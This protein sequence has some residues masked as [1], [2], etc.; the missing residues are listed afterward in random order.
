V[1]AEFDVHDP[2][3]GAP[4]NGYPNF[5]YST[6][7]E[8]RAQAVGGLMDQRYV[9]VYLQDELGLLENKL[10]L[11]LAGRYTYVKQSEWGADASAAKHVTPRIGLSG[12]INS[13][14]AVYALYDQAFI[15]QSG[16]LANGDKVQPITGNNMEVGVK[17]DW[18]AG[19]WNSTLSVYRILKNNELAA[20][21][22]SPPA[23]GLSVELG[24]KRAQ[25]VEFD[26]RGTI[27]NG[28]S[29]IANYAYTDSRITKV[30]EGITDIEEGDVVPGYARHT[31][32]TWLSYK[33]SDGWLKGVGISAGL[34]YLAERETYW[35]PSPDPSQQ[36]P[37]YFKV[38]AGLFWERDNLR[39]TANVFNILDEYLYSGSYYTWLNAYYWQTD[40]PR[41]VRL[42]LAYKF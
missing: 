13:Q 33:I 10:R 40:P 12:S 22:A 2:Y 31:M 7:L 19:K 4:V 5:D 18:A 27:V 8:E 30:T 23:S 9:A 14:T 41:N 37:D 11:T 17:R 39:I 1:G 26:V 3:Y 38:D 28:L 35:D 21:P 15:P 20:D 42:S 32:N 24:Q 36:L 25:G 6:P 16:R 29:V 34:T